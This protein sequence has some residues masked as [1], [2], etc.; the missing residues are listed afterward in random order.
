MKSPAWIASLVGAVVFYGWVADLPHLTSVC[1]GW[2]TTKPLTAVCL[3][4]S[5][6]VVG[7]MRADGDRLA[8]VRSTAVM[9]LN[10][11]WLLSVW[12]LST[13]TPNAFWKV[14]ASEKMGAIE[15]TG[16]GVPSLMTLLS[17]AVVCGLGWTSFWRYE[18][19]ERFAGWFFVGT[20]LVAIVLGYGADIETARY[21]VEG[22]ST[23]YAFPTAV[24]F[25]CIGVGCLKN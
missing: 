21:Y 7:L 1:P 6:V 22:F 16:P 10:L 14:F 15:S 3:I 20:A 2:V 25:L 23:G 4:L 17:L 8:L 11:L 19:A 5:G 24:G 18:K 9:W 12:A 13:H